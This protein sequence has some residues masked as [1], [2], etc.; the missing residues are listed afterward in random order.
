[1]SNLGERMKCKLLSFV[2]SKDRLDYIS[3]GDVFYIRDQVSF[4]QYILVA[5]LLDIESYCANGD[6]SFFYSNS[7]SQCLFSSNYSS[8]IQERNNRNFLNLINSV[9]KEGYDDNSRIRINY[10][11]Y[12]ADGTHRAAMCYHIGKKYIPVKYECVP[13]FFDYHYVEQIM[14]KPEC[15]ELYSVLDKKINT[16]QDD[17]VKNNFLCSCQI[18]NDISSEKLLFIKD[19][20]NAISRYVCEYIT[21]NNKILIG[22]LP[23]DFKYIVKNKRLAFKSAFKLKEE[24]ERNIEGCVIDSSLIEGESTLSRLKCKI[25]QNF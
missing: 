13:V 2:N 19:R 17:L 11:F 22:F 7:L 10:K 5:R 6:D 4:V 15:R 8:D 9:K 24:L 18:P 25:I 14:S 1:M 23:S 3:L 16:I 12:V 20:I 21:D